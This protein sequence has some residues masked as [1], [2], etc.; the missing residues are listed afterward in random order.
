MIRIN[1]IKINKNK[2]KRPKKRKGSEKVCRPLVR[3]NEKLSTNERLVERG[4]FTLISG[5]S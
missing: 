5:S 2:M 3:E 1:F 4:I